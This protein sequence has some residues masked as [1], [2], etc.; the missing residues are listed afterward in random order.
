[1]KE[2]TYFNK[3]S[4]YLKEVLI[5]IVEV[6]WMFLICLII[7][8]FGIKPHPSLI[9]FTIIFI[10]WSLYKSPFIL[11]GIS[12]AVD[13]IFKQFVEM[14][15]EYV[16]TL[17]Y[18]SSS[19]NDKK[20]GKYRYNLFYYQLYV[21]KHKASQYIYLTSG[22]KFNFEKGTESRLIVGKCSKVILEIL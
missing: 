15:L 18:Y 20:V 21:F 12:V 5:W 8:I 17:K 7:N 19:F 11:R 14:D 1:M 16:D 22:E 9:A 10:L 4:I 3:V 13:L 6:I 2:K